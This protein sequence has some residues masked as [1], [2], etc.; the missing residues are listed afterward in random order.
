MI[1]EDPFPIVDSI[2]IAGNSWNHG[3]NS[4]WS[5]KK[6]IQ[7]IINKGILEFLEKKR[8]HGD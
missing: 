4:Y 6:I 8:G 3:T 7:D 2:N 1:D 5:F